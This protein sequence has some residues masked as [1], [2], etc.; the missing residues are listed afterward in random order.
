MAA[1][2][3]IWEAS[4]L[5]TEPVYL[6]NGCNNLRLHVKAGYWTRIRTVVQAISGDFLLK[7][8]GGN[9]NTGHRCKIGVL[10][11]DGVYLNVI[12]RIL[13]TPFQGIL[14]SDSGRVDVVINCPNEWVGDYELPINLLKYPEPNDAEPISNRIGTLVVSSTAITDTSEGHD[15]DIVELPEWKPCRPFYLTDLTRLWTS[16]VEPEHNNIMVNGMGVNGELY[17]SEKYQKRVLQEG[18][19]LQW[20]LESNMNVNL[21]VSTNKM[22]IVSGPLNPHYAPE[23]DQVGDWINMARI[24]SVAQTSV[25]LDASGNI[26]FESNPSLVVRLVLDR[27]GGGMEIESQNYL[28]ADSGVKGQYLINGGQQ[29]TVNGVAMLRYGT[30]RPSSPHPFGGEAFPAPGV[31]ES[32]N[33]D[34]GGIQIGYGY[35]HDEDNNNSNV[36]DVPFIQKARRDTAVQVH[37]SADVEQSGGAYEVVGLSAGDWLSYSFKVDMTDTYKFG[38]RMRSSFGALA[39]KL[40]NGDCES[41]EGF[42][43]DIQQLEF[44]KSSRTKEDFQSLIGLRKFEIPAGLHRLFLCVSK[45]DDISL[46][47]ISILNAV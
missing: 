10:A 30:C 8:F 19:V 33:F 35:Y 18:Q 5:I 36:K 29:S 31:F 20:S 44:E 37:D 1:E 2:D 34:E 16:S 15:I 45:G 26:N 3:S 17:E 25:H 40:N 12:P 22:Q 13:S 27:W 28:I 6:T 47:T 46:S 32:A 7:F 43:D 24:R 41:R 11:K 21:H 42:T 14:V 23:W 38:V 4:S 9:H 39:I